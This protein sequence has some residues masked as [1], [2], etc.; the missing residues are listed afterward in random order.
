MNASAASYVPSA[1]TRIALEQRSAKQS[2]SAT[3]VISAASH[4]SVTATPIELH[5]PPQQEVTPL[6]LKPKVP[7]MSERLRELY[8]T[9]AAGNEEAKTVE[10]PPGAL[11]LKKK[12]PS[13]PPPTNPTT[14]PTEKL[15]RTRYTVDEIRALEEVS[16]QRIR[17]GFIV[18][19]PPFL[20]IPYDFAQLLH[21]PHALEFLDVDSASA[22]VEGCR[23][24]S[25]LTT[26]FANHNLSIYDY[27]CPTCSA[28]ELPCEAAAE[29]LRDVKRRLLGTRL[30]AI[31]LQGPEVVWGQI[32][33][34]LVFEMKQSSL[35][36]RMLAEKNPGIPRLVGEYLYGEGYHILI[37]P[38]TAHDDWADM[39]SLLKFDFIL[40][41]KTRVK[42]DLSKQ[43]RKRNTQFEQFAYFFSFRDDVPEQNSTLNMITRSVKPGMIAMLSGDIAAMVLLANLEFLIPYD[44]FWSVFPFLDD[45]F[46]SDSPQYSLI[47]HVGLY[48]SSKQKS[49]KFNP[50]VNPFA[51]H[52]FHRGV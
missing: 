11:P 16:L 8:L 46:G 32:Q 15:G 51:P 42:T 26:D 44:Y 22:L 48:L 40:K 31:L 9:P 6:S 36:L 2:A 47:R 1:Q 34:A 52:T 5:S 24:S 18:D 23:Y 3:P 35:R 29:V 19:S 20:K 50:I 7:T 33:L 27:T 38:V 17:Q 25:P 30:G 21:A 49:N 43:W 28:G 12:L 41:N 4:K 10:F 39:N 37:P 45:A 14:A 13:P